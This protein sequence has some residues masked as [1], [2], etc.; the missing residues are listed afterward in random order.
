MRGGIKAR[1]LA[2]VCKGLGRCASCGMGTFGK[3]S[4]EKVILRILI[5]F[6]M[7]FD[8]I[9]GIITHGGVFFRSLLISNEH[10]YSSGTVEH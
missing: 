3:G 7:C 5:Q 2:K 10:V 1:V 4:R 9:M 8:T 6:F